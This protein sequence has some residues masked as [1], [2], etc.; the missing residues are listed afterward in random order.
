VEKFARKLVAERRNTL[1]NFSFLRDYTDW[2]GYRK[3]YVAIIEVMDCHNA[4]EVLADEIEKRHGRELR[5]QYLSKRCPPWEPMKRRGVP[6][7]E[8]LWNEWHYGSLP[9]R[10]VMPGFRFSTG[11]LPTFGVRVTRRIRRSIGSV[12]I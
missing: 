9:R 6:I 7:R 10:H 8:R 12:R 3:L 1:E 4:L 2:L 5:N 11:F